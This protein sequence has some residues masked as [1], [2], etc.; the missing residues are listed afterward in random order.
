VIATSEQAR[1]PR[2]LHELIVDSGATMMQATPATW[3]GLVDIAPDGIRLRRALCGGEALS[4]QLA[5]ALTR[6][7]AA[8][9]NLYGPTEATIWSTVAPLRAGASPVPL[10]TP[11]AATRV[12]VLDD[13]LEPVP[14]GVA[15]ELY[16]GGAGL[17]RGYHRRPDLTAQR[18]IPD[19]HDPTPGQRLYRTG[20]RAR[21]RPD[22]TLDYL[23]RTDHQIKLRG[24]RIE[25][26]EVEAALTSHPD[27][28]RALVTTRT[29]GPGD[30]RLVAY[31]TPATVR[32]DDLR[33]HLADTLPHHMIPSETLALDA[34][35]LTP[36][37]KIDRT[38]LP[39]PTP[40]L[41]ARDAPTPPTSEAEAVVA[42]IWQDV[43]GAPNIGVDDDF[44]ALGGHSLLAAKVIA[45]VDAVA[46]I[47]VPLQALFTHRTIRSLADL[48]EQLILDDISG[49]EVR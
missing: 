4:S 1:D 49:T 42:A 30:D 33:A 19:P 6:L 39:D 17:A 32:T 20:D 35:P 8:A 41:H 47:S 12:L 9:F 40:R 16:I 23:G 5:S 28:H 34:F 48:I 45:R 15:G 2:L 37:G 43:L 11:V 31:V 44:F 10:G 3:Q 36:N 24:F 21:R 14:P 27:V 13:A 46:G 29:A 25:P 38:N 26:G 22:G 7:G 18:F